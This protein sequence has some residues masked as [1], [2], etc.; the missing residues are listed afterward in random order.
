VWGNRPFDDIRTHPERIE[1]PLHWTK[2]RKVF[3]NSVSD[4]FHPFLFGLRDGYENKFI[5]STDTP[6]LDQVFAV[7]AIARQHTY[8]VLTKRSSMMCWYMIDPIVSQRVESQVERIAGEHGY[9]PPDFVWPLPNVWLGVSIENQ[10]TANARVPDL[11]RT[12]ARVRFVSCEPLLGPIEL[13]D[14]DGVISQAMGDSLLYPADLIDW[15][16][17][18]G[19]SGPNARPAHPDWFRSLR[20]QCQASNIPFFFKQWGEWKP[21]GKLLTNIEPGLI[22]PTQFFFED[23]ICMQKVGKKNAGHLLDEQEWREY[24]K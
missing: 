13:F 7:M 22:N 15:V 23:G 17:S 11:L 9:C 10:E 16:I 3:V 21:A 24:P 14:V 12:P 4:L 20:D 19:E 18:G 5:T 8:Q 6:F 1:Q 2:P